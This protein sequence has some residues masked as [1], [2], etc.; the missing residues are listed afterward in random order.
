MKR[1]TLIFATMLAIV[2]QAYGNDTL[3][4]EV[5]IVRNFTPTVSDADKINTLPPITTPLF[6]RDDVTYAFDAFSAGVVSVPSKI[7]MPSLAYVQDSVTRY[8]GYANFDMGMYMAM[9]ANAGYRILDTKSDKLGVAAQF[10]SLNGDIPIGS[11]VMLLSDKTHQTFYDVRAGLHYAHV[12]S[13]N[14]TMALNASYRYAHF[15]YYGV[16]G[17][18]NSPTQQVNSCMVELRVDNSEAQQYDYE[19]WHVL[20]GYKLYDNST[21]LYT[22]APSREHDAYIDLSYQY[23][24]DDHWSVGGDMKG[25]YLQYNGLLGVPYPD[26]ESTLLPHEILT[27]HIFMMRLLPYATWNKGRASLRAGLKMDISVGDGNVFCVAPDV[28]F[29]WEFIH[30]YYLFANIGG[31]K[32]LNRW[33][34]V[35]QYCL[36]FDPSQQIASSYSPLD[37][38]LGVRMHIIPELYVTLY[39]GYE[40]A[41]RA[42]FQQVDG[43]SQTVVWDAIDA[44]CFKAGLALDARITEYV[45]LTADAAYR[46]WSHNG[47]AITYNRPRWEANVAAVV[48]PL[49]QLDVKVDYNMQ[50]E[51]DYGVYGK[52]ADVHNLQLSATYRVFDWL[53]VSLHGNNLLNRRHDYYFGLPAPGIQVMGGVAV[54]F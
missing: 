38:L 12:F 6:E 46:H 29:N 53:S 4:R 8:N 52:L 41:D 34:D 51:R 37:A 45:T 54:K 42:L 20:A 30:N 26:A 23:M 15:N 32:Q 3:Q 9:A 44:Q 11:H 40:V 33:N 19:K 35:S 7:D 22:Q 47:K 25:E 50:L 43:F 28:R 24:L 5:T 10:T 13:N 14:I 36:Y 39:G 2:L 1:Y 27:E 48:H 31:G 18:G 49:K 21:A 17:E 16:M